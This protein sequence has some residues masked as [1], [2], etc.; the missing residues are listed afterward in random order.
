MARTE[1]SVAQFQDLNPVIHERSRLAIMTLLVSVKEAT[2]TELKSE[3]G[4][5]DGN[6]NLHMKVLEKHGFVTVDKAFVDRRPR[7]SYRLT[8]GG[9]KAFA[10]YVELLEDILGLKRDRTGRK[11]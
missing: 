6:V 7:T 11:R 10:E 3:L 8:A 1:A 9:R 5:T 2:F 4:L